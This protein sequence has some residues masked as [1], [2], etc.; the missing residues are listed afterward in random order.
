[1]DV[2]TI[3]ALVGAHF[4]ADG[5]APG[6]AATELRAWVAR[7]R[8]FEGQNIEYVSYDVDRSRRVPARVAVIRNAPTRAGMSVWRHSGHGRPPEQVREAWSVGHQTSRFH[9][10]T[11]GVHRRYPRGRHQSEEMSVFTIRSFYSQRCQIHKARN[12]ME[13]S[14]KSLHASVRCVLRQAW[15]L[16]DAA[17]AERL[18]RNLAQRSTLCARPRSPSDTSHQHQ[19]CSCPHSPRGRLRYADRLRRPRWRNGQP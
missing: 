7:V 4:Q 1:M 19:R 2:T 13:R 14:P 12:I 3:T 18:L 11:K 16:D 8:V 17:K 10:F 15:E 9:V 6:Y 5:F